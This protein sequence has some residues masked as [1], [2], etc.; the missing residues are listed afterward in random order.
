VPPTNQQVTEV[1]DTAEPRRQKR[2]QILDDTEIAALYDRPCSTPEERS[3][4]FT[5]TQP[6]RDARAGLRA[7]LS[8][9][10]FT[11]QLAYFKDKQRF[12]CFTF[13]DAA[14]DVA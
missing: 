14:A 11:L 3:L 9:L 12:F 6:E 7:L 10:Y 2:L 1:L 5:L 13:A 4:Y 8:Q